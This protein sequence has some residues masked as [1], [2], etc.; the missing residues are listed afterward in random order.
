MSWIGIDFGAKRVG[1]AVSQSGSISTP[2]EVVDRGRGIDRVFEAIEAVATEYE[3]HT[4]IVGIP[5]GGR[6][7]PSDN[8][9]LYR[10][11]ADQLRQRV[12][13][14]VILW[15]EAYSTTEASRLA[16]EAGHRR[17]PRGKIDSMEVVLGNQAMK[18]STRWIFSRHWRN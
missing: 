3:A 13:L 11:F 4:I 17:P 6:K 9:L 15:D 18:L 7:A 12:D 2:L 16:K 5:L 8:L 10:E 14:E 1:I